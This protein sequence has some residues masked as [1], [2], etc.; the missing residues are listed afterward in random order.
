MVSDNTPLRFQDFISEYLKENHVECSRLI[1]IDLE[2]LLQHKIRDFTKLT[3]KKI[4]VSDEILYKIASI[5]FNLSKNEK[6]G[7]LGARINL[8]VL[9]KDGTYT[10]IARFAYDPCI[11]TSFEIF[12]TLKEHRQILF[13]F[14]LFKNDD[15]RL[16]IRLNDFEYSKRTFVL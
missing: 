10:E 15:N 9:M 12:I 16:K 14:R 5:V 11:L 1:I 4:C 2:R 13:N 6:Y 3:R 7:I 8:K